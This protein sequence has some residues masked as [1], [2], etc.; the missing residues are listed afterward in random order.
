MEAISE[1]KG[2]TMKKPTLLAPAG[3]YEKMTAAVHYGADAVYLSGKTFGMRAAA[4]N[5][6]EEELADAVAFAHRNGAAVHVT[7]NVMPR[8]EEYE[9][10]GDYLSFLDSIRPD[11]LIVADMGVIAMAK[12]KAPHLPLHLS[13]QASVVSA[14]AAN[15]Y[16]EIGIKRIVL[17]RELSLDEIASIRAKTPSSLELETFI[18]G[19]MCVSYSG[20]CLL[21]NYLAGR[22]GNRGMCAQPCRWEYRM[23][24]V[25][26]KKRPGQFIP[27]GEDA[28][29]T[30]VMS[31][32]DLC[33][34]SHLGELC[35]AGIDCFKIEGRMKSVYYVSAVTNA[36]RMAL[37]AALSGRKEVDPAWLRELESVSHR[38]Y[39]TGYYFGK[40]NE[41]ANLTD[42]I[43]PLAEAS[44][45]AL[46]LTDS[47]ASGSALF[48]QKNKS[49]AGESVEWLSPGRTGLPFTVDGLTDEEGNEISSTPHPQMKYYMKVPFPVKKGDVIRR[50]PLL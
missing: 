21:S 7:V 37:D 22:D 23:A 16:H 46:A 6:S 2:I 43:A 29:G 24:Y 19:A 41:T 35:D 1:G 15:A 11:A 18:H 32:R 42:R 44:F 30:Y 3:N 27:V 8:G 14:E 12:K 26:E 36:Y 38:E 47:D 10:L 20:R 9:A 34:I 25:E 28:F 40:P 49:V 39:S 4:G 5:F 45:V 50:C 48:E 17:A 13:T 33:M 31:S